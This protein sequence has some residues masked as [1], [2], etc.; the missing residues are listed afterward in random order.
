MTACNLKYYEGVTWRYS[1]FLDKVPPFPMTFLMRKGILLMLWYIIIK[2]QNLNDNKDW[3][4]NFYLTTNLT[5]GFNEL[6]G[7]ML[8]DFRGEAF[9]VLL[10]Y[11][12]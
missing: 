3:V 2:L 12:W 8:R 10:S 11:M 9:F 4:L 1:Y 6:I 7:I 5:I